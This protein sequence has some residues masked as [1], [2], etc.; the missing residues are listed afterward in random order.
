MV[1]ELVKQ[2]NIAKHVFNEAFLYLTETRFD[3][4]SM[5]L[6]TNVKANIFV[7]LLWQYTLGVKLKIIPTLY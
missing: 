3:T 7:S 6:L 1:E 2:N 5:V 4:N